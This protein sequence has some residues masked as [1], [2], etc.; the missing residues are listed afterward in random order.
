MT[1]RTQRFVFVGVAVLVIGLG[2]GIVASYMGLPNLGLANSGPAE[3]AYVPAD[4]LALGFADVRTVMDSELRHKLQSVAPGGATAAPNGLEAETGI[5]IETDVDRVVAAMSGVGGA[6]PLLVVRG[7]FDTAR[8][9]A[10]IRSKGGTVEEYGGQRLISIE[11]DGHKFG[12]AFVEPGLAVAGEPATVRRAID[13]KASGNSIT[14]NA[15][16]MRFVND[17]G[18]ANAWGVAKFD[19]LTNGT[20]VPPELHQQ[21]PP[22]TWVAASG[23]IGVGVDA[24]VRAETR[25]EMAANN[26]RDVIRGFVALARMQTSQHPQF[27][28]LVNSIELGGQGTTVSLSFSVPGSLLDVL[29]AMPRPTTTPQEQPPAARAPRRPLPATL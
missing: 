19:A 2:T 3:L 22:V 7:R 13:T 28:D 6:P 29:G 4:T 27:A 11:S 18:S 1:I 20:L 17:F 26:L 21:L 25:D 14:N 10:A 15:D 5:N 9:E 12:L 23:R 16:V 24:M 8:I